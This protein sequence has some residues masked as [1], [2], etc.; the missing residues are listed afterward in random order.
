M[1][2]ALEVLLHLR[3]FDRH[4]HTG[5]C[6]H[7]HTAHTHTGT[8]TCTCRL[9]RSFS[10]AQGAPMA[11]EGPSRDSLVHKG[12]SRGSPGALKRLSYAV[13][14]SL[15]RMQAFEGLS[16]HTHTHA[17]LHACLSCTFLWFQ[18]RSNLKALA[19]RSIPV[20]SMRPF[21]YDMLDVLL[22]PTWLR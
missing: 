4:M 13:L 2:E 14:C 5:T 9:L 19:S 21:G 3:S 18:Q 22:E 12:L 7:T 16:Q 20:C 17:C 11:L 15:R 8:C 1:L 10:G 6:T